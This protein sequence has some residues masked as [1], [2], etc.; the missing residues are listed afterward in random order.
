MKI[1][2]TRSLIWAISA[3]LLGGYAPQAS[4]QDALISTCNIRG[5]VK[6]VVAGVTTSYPLTC[7]NPTAQDATGQDDSELVGTTQL[8]VPAVTN[9]AAVSAPFAA[10]ERLESPD[11]IM[12]G[13]YAGASGVGMVQGGVMATDVA[14]WTSCAVP[15]QYADLHCDVA[16]TIG[17][18]VVGGQAVPVPSGPIPI[19]TQIPIASLG[20][21]VN[22]PGLGGLPGL[23]VVNVPLQGKLT[24]NNIVI[25][26][27]GTNALRIEHAPLALELAGGLYVGAIPVAVNIKIE[28]YTEGYISYGELRADSVPCSAQ[29]ASYYNCMSGASASPYTRGCSAIAM[30]RD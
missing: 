28:D 18:L 6:V 5:S 21:A 4:S 10:S 30:C 13:A 9:V 25:T 8:G 7:V 2:M 1:Y 22:L 12:F 14:G 3:V 19:N 27:V 17:T 16:M 15:T 20:L 24:L 26:E 29:G 11:S 23:G